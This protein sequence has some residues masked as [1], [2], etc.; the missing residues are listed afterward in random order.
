MKISKQDIPW[1]SLKVIKYPPRMRSQAKHRDIV[2]FDTETIDGYC[3]LITDSNGR[4]LWC[5]KVDGILDFLTYRGYRGCFGTF[6]NLRYDAQAVLKYLPGDLLQE[7]YDVGSTR[8]REYEIH[9]IPK[10]FWSITRGGRRYT[11]YDV[12]Q[13]YMT[14]L[15]KAGHRYLGRGKDLGGI[16]RARLGTDPDYW[17]DKLDRILH[18]CIA[19]S[20]L[21]RDLTEHLVETY[22][23]EIGYYPHNLISRA[24]VAKN[25]LRERVL[26]PNIT[27]IPTGALRMSFSAYY[28]GRFEVLQKGHFSRAWGYDLNSAYPHHISKL[29]DITRGKWKDTFNFGDGAYYGYYQVKIRY[30]KQDVGVVPFRMG[31]GRVCFPV[32]EFAT[33]INRS[34]YE[35]LEKVANIEIL[36]GWEFYPDEIIYPFRDLVYHVYN[37]KNQ[38]DKSTFKYDLYKRLLNSIY[39]SFY[40]KYRQGGRYRTGLMFN[41]VYATE[42]T[43][44][45]RLDC[46][47]ILRQ[48]GN[49]II[50]VATDGILFDE[51]PEIP[52]SRDLGQWDLDGSGDLTVLRSGV[53]MLDDKYRSRGVEKDT[54]LHTPDG[55]YD[56]IFQYIIAKPD[57]LEYEILRRRPRQLGECLL[58]KRELTPDDINKFMDISYT[59]QINGDYKR[60]FPDS[61][62]S[63]GEIFDRRIKSYPLLFLD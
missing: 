56:N 60:Y 52:R 8:Y 23:G 30:R 63:G 48:S 14:S 16:D 11:F 17:S 27:K 50:S 54:I 42:I 6:Y 45:T 20:V 7:L 26:L 62:E 38:T 4:F 57:K 21:C 61:F 59:I 37:V 44:G 49:H 2:G 36:R 32:G 46:L 25:Y 22:S 31:S 58:H 18:Y 13:F 12:A 41:P 10:K 53:Y 35:Q 47:K 28:G 40:E 29:I 33:V 15:E 3:R 43:A 9:Y 19:D 39:G 24:S 51:D 34:E 5:D 1:R 55:T